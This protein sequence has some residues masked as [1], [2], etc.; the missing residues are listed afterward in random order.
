MM[1]RYLSTPLLLL[2]AISLLGCNE[3]NEN[4]GGHEQQGH[5]SHEQQKHGS[6]WG[7]SGEEGPE[8]WGELNPDYVACAAGKNQTPINITGMV[9]A[10]LPALV[11]DYKVEGGQEIVNNGHTIQVNYAP[12]STITVDGIAFELLQFHY[13]SPSENN[14][15][16][17]SYPMEVHFVHKDKDGNLAVLALMY[18]E[19]A[20]NQELQKAWGEMPQA[21]G[22]KA[23]L[24]AAV[25]AGAL[26]PSNTDYYRF[27]GSL[28]TPPCS[29]GV[30]WLTLKAHSTASKQQIE[31]F[32]HVMHHPNN[33]PLQ[34]LNSRVIL[35]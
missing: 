25:S 18:E 4:N 30:R 24:K 31:A 10:E 12:G 17:K 8:H 5:G 16:G 26:L 11:L 19:G 9:E 21:A 22:Q 23:N 3:N 33:R 27:N 6:H 35:Q 29:E 13:H 32:Q 7:Y 34:P 1:R 2:A 20:E 28:T 14:I 15:D